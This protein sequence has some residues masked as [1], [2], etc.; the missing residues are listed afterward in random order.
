M[1]RNAD[2]AP[3][4]AEFRVRLEE[5]LERLY[6]EKIPL[7]VYE[8]L[9]TPHRQAL[10]YARGRSG[11]GNVV[12]KSRAWRSFH[13]YGLAADMVFLDGNGRWSWAEPGPGMWDRYHA[14]AKDAGLEVLSFERPHVQLRWEVG[15]LIRGIYPSGGGHAV[16][17]WLTTSADLWGH[18]PRIINGIEHP[19]APLPAD[20][21]ERPDLIA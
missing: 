1:S 20:I 19:G 4:H 9:R 21:D 2:L 11:L 3:L 6:K 10:L 5:V 16:E 18:D 14:I 13:Q 15:D 17:E 8:T 12:T 7:Q